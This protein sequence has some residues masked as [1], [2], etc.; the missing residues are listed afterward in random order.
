M[1]GEAVGIVALDEVVLHAW[2]L[3]RAT[4]QSYDPDAR[5]LDPL[6]GFLT[7]MAEGGTGIAR[8]GIFGPVVAVADDAP[9]FDR[10]LGLSGRDP[11]WTPR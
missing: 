3:A 5:V 6:M 11:T 2:D 9:Q 1:P 4:D 8:D 10:V 7:H